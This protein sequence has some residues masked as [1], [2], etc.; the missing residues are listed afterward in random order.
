M[1]NIDVVGV[2]NIS[3]G[4][5]CGHTRDDQGPQE[6]GDRTIAAAGAGQFLK[7]G[8]GNRDASV[9][10]TMTMATTQ[11]DVS[12]R[13]VPLELLR[14]RA[15]STGTASDLAALRAEEQSRAD[16]D[17][18]FRAIAARIAG[19]DADALLRAGIQSIADWDCYR[20]AIDAYEANCRPLDDY[21]L[22]WTSLLAR[23]CNAY[24]M[25][26]VVVGIRDTC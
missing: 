19:A 16:Y 15:A 8:T 7:E 17:A 4:Q 1:E 10:V 21:S 22:K 13:D 14:R 24:P 5:V 3:I 6:Y 2:N 12:S 23:L 9:A 20:A 25:H 18:S 26:A 11:R